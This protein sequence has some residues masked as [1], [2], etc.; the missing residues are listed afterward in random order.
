MCSI[1]VLI[2]V[3]VKR[4]VWRLQPGYGTL[5]ATPGPHSPLIIY[6]HADHFLRKEIK[7]SARR[8][9]AAS[10]ARTSACSYL[11]KNTI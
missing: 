11:G 2:F 9:N 1:F 3:F 6:G 7:V 8:T 10:Y 4:M 5:I